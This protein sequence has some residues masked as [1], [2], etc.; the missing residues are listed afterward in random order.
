MIARSASVFYGGHMATE[1]WF[2][3]PKDYARELAE[4]GEA[5]LAWDRG[6]L[7]KRGID[8]FA[9]AG[10]F[11]GNNWRARLIGAQGTME[12]DPEH[13]TLHP[14]AVYPTW[15]YGEPSAL[16]E[17]MM[18]NPVGQDEAACFDLTTQVDERP[19][20]GQKHVVVV[21]EGPPQGG[22]TTVGRKFFRWLSELQADYP[23]CELYVHGLYGF[24]LMFGLGF[25]AVDADPR[26]DAQKGKVI[27]SSGQIVPFENAQKNPKWLAAV[28]MSISDIAVPRN[29][30]IFNIR[31]MLWAGENYGKIFNFKIDRGGH[32]VDAKTPQ[33]NYDAEG[34]KTF[35]IQSRHPK[36][37]DY[38]ACD[39]CSL[40][41][42][43]SYE[44]EGAVCSVPNSDGSRLARYFK[45]RD[46]DMIIDGLGELMSLGASRVETAMQEEEVMGLDPQVTAML[47]SLFTQGI[48]LAKLVD[49]SLRGAKVNVNVG[50]AAGG[51]AQID[52]G[53]KNAIIAGVVRQ[54]ELEG[55]PRDKITPE[56][57]EGA[58][59]G[60]ASPETQRRAIKGQVIGDE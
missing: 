17:E 11:F 9:H 42:V 38:V 36:E 15:C 3:N 18:A 45:T 10:L 28:G 37:G 48:Q 1:V 7:I 21:A 44:R 35:L 16:L 41:D 22:N 32:K 13:N 20:W 12:I 8:P 53:N 55:V 34:R 6:M 52:T 23:E 51:Q 14:A 54:F 24:R 27:L 50:V 57:I 40:R 4:V 47:S 26:T 25:R 19:I 2:R 31:S 58:L 49:P 60:M 30:C 5:R 39:Q 43:C 56:M 46:S 59:A 29:R 33:I